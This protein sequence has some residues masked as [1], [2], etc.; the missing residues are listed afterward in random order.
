MYVCNILSII[1]KAN[2]LAVSVVSGRHPGAW[3]AQGRDGERKG[4][5]E[6]IYGLVDG[7]ADGWME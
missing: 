7:Y 5:T 6:R 1:S 3:G 4:W 2:E